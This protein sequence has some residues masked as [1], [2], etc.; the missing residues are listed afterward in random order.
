MT[1]KQLHLTYALK[2]ETITNIAD[3]ES[4]LKCGCKCPACG[5]QLIAKKGKKVMHHFAHHTGHTCE[6]G[7]ESSLHLAAKD[8]L[9]KAKKIVVPPVYLKFPHS[10]KNDELISEAKEINIEKVELENRF[11]DIIP[12][13]VL[14]TDNK[15]LFIEIFVTH[16]IDD[17]K[18]NKL[19]KANFSTIEIDLS[20]RNETIS[21]EELTELLLGNSDEKKWKY[22]AVAQNYLQRFYDVADKRKL[23]DRGL[24]THVDHCPIESRVWKGKP[25]ANFIDD[26]LCCEYC[27]E[28]SGEQEMLCTGRKRIATI[29]DLDIPADI[30]IRRKI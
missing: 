23:I 25:Y 3:V 20:K 9:S 8:I 2:D 11:H 24:A 17:E 6:Y 16:C 30:R 26:C 1:K 27:I 13:I 14:Y 28:S 22:N 21:G 29:Q 12:D 10:Y 4:G 7:Y 5:E 15:Q 18:F 19:C